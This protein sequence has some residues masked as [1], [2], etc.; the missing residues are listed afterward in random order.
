[1]RK[2]YFLVILFLILAIF[3][4]G[5][6][7]GV[8]TPATDETKV[9]GVIQGFWSAL[10]NKQCELAKTYCIPYGNAY[11]AV[12]EYQ[13]LFGYDYATIN[14]TPYINW[15]EI[16]GNEATVNMNLTL[17]VTVCFGNTCS[18]ESETLYN[19]YMYLIKIDGAWKLK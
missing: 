17:T 18:T 13:N 6:G 14:W 7:G 10:S 4:N 2:V 19:F 9:K 16:I 15:V 5:C 3:L 1:M 12:E 11:N 8:V